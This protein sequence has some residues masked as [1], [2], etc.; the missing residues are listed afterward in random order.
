ME[1][2]SIETKI[3]YNKINLIIS[4]V[5]KGEE[6]AEIALNIIK[7]EFM[8]ASKIHISGINF[9]DIADIAFCNMYPDFILSE[10]IKEDYPHLHSSQ[11]NL[12]KGFLER[13]IGH[14]VRRIYRSEINIDLTIGATKIDEHLVKS[15]FY[16]QTPILE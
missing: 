1:K 4:K 14:F 8:K 9:S 15:G 5:G 13:A 7:E 11:K 3:N 10:I 6:K 16:K 2:F 12:E